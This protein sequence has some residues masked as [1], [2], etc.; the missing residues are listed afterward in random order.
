MA[1]NK[2][3]LRTIRFVGCNKKFNIYHKRKT[4]NARWSQIVTTSKIEDKAIIGKII[5]L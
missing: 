4:S 2:N 1:P 5:N 3:D